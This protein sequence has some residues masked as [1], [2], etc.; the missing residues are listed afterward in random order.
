MELFIADGSAA[1]SRVNYPVD[2]DLD[3]HFF[4]E[5]G[6]AT[7]IRSRVIWRVE[8]YPLFQNRYQP[9]PSSCDKGLYAYF[10]SAVGAVD[11]PGY[12]LDPLAAKAPN[13]NL[14]PDKG[15]QAMLTIPAI[16]ATLR[17]AVPALVPTRSSLS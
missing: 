8:F 11:C 9:A 14:L 15:L 10:L 5:G 1:V 6:T 17:D 2:E 13:S 12:A 16:V 3:V 7:G 4:A